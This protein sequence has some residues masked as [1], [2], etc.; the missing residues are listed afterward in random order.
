[1]VSPNVI[2][3]VAASI[4]S[5]APSSAAWTP[6]TLRVSASMTSLTAPRVSQLASA[7]GTSRAS[8]T[9][10]SQSCPAAMACSS[11]IP[12]EAICG[13]VNVTPGSPVSY[14]DGGIG[15]GFGSGEAPGLRSDVDIL[16]CPAHVPGREDP[17][18]AG[19]LVAVHDEE[20]PLVGLHARGL[21]AEVACVGE[22]ARRHEQPLTLR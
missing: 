8:R 20:A 18:V 19:A 7:R 15:E 4:M 2:A 14:D 22:P 13:V 10:Q 17:G 16:R 3:Y 12:A 1:M 9:R 11:V 6:S 21:E 5:P